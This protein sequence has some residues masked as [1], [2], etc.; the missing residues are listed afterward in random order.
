[1][2]CPSRRHVPTCLSWTTAPRAA[3]TSTS[4]HS[5][6]RRWC[7]WRSGRPGAATALRETLHGDY[8]ILTT[9]TEATAIL[10]SIRHHRELTYNFARLWPGSALTSKKQ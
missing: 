7:N 6:P 1:M 3:L 10:P 8:L 9:L 4:R 5:Q 2:S